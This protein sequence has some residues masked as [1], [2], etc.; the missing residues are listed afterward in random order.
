MNPPSVSDRGMALGCTDLA[1][2]S[3]E[4]LA[5]PG[6]LRI[7]KLIFKVPVTICNPIQLAVTDVLL[8]F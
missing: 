1:F 7:A 5:E 8:I 2:M 4:G 3:V 6:L